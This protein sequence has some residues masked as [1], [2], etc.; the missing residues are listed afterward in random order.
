MSEWSR[1]FAWYPVEDLQ[2]WMWLRFVEYKLHEEDGA[3]S[4]WWEYRRV[5]A[6]DLHHLE[7]RLA[8]MEQNQETIIR[9]LQ[10]THLSS[11]SQLMLNKAYDEAIEI[12]TKI[13]KALAK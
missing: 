6:M 9:L 10:H 8:R 12:V 7:K 11:L 3:T 5:Q 1:W 4:D 2:G 13:K